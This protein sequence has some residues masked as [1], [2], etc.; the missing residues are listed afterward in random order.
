MNEIDVLFNE[1]DEELRK[2]HALCCEKN[3]VLARY[4]D[5]QVQNP[6]V[7]EKALYE[8]IFF[9]RDIVGML[10]QAK[11]GIERIGAKQYRDSSWKP[12]INDLQLA[13]DKNIAEEEGSET[14]GV[15]HVKML[16]DGINGTLQLKIPSSAEPSD[17]T[18]VFLEELYSLLDHNNA[19]SLPNILGAVYAIESSAVPELKVVEILLDTTINDYIEKNPFTLSNNFDSSRVTLKKF[20][21]GHLETWEPGHQDDLNIT[22]R[23]FLKSPLAQQKFN[24]S[25]LRVLK[26]MEIWWAEIS[27]EIFSSIISSNSLSN[28]LL[29]REERIKGK[30]IS[31]GINSERSAEYIS[32][33]LS[34][35]HLLGEKCFPL[36]FIDILGNDSQ[37]L[38]FGALNDQRKMITKGEIR[39]EDIKSSLKKLLRDI[40]PGSESIVASLV[41]VVNPDKT[42]DGLDYF[43]IPRSKQFNNNQF[44]Q[45][46]DFIFNQRTEAPIVQRLV[47]LASGNANILLG[48]SR[49]Q[50]ANAVSELAAERVYAQLESSTRIGDGLEAS[51]HSLGNWTK[52]ILAS[53]YRNFKENWNTGQED[54]AYPYLQIIRGTSTFT[55]SLIR[56]LRGKSSLSASP[57]RHYSKNEENI[58]LK[59][60]ILKKDIELLHELVEYA[61][62]IHIQTSTDLRAN[63]KIRSQKVLLELLMKRFNISSVNNLESIFNTPKVS[64]FL[65]F[66]REPIWNITPLGTKEVEIDFSISTKSDQLVIEIHQHES[67]DKDFKGYA[68]AESRGIKSANEVFN[69]EHYK[70]GYVGFPY[71][72]E[73]KRR[74]DKYDT[75]I[76]TRLILFLR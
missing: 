45:L 4:R 19:D 72:Q 49:F 9:P 28:I 52:P 47:I 73:S 50:L 23:P 57:S 61:I 33:I 64:A 76:K 37:S 5:L 34:S 24:D 62:Q 38:S 30:E 7:L 51:V 40:Y 59:A 67:T 1:L 18:R 48:Q 75:T 35:T 11:T 54:W 16:E 10:S 69:H 3:P 29:L 13:L 46:I 71:I 53:A 21:K 36:T 31:L 43:H 12:F 44:D 14:S 2:C 63:K 74:R 39:S 8:Y 70:Y 6:K 68:I 15:P 65:E 55:K 20:M 66:I 22:C 60:L 25:F 58:V 26:Q 56:Y 17:F 27:E 41:V 42:K 32:G